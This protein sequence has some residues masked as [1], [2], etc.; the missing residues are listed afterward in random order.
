MT[1]QHPDLAWPWDQL[2]EGWANHIA[3]R[4]N[5]PVYLVGSALREERPRDIDIRIVLTDEAFMQRYGCPRWE[6]DFLGHDVSTPAVVRYH[7][8]MAKHGE[9]AGRH[10]SRGLNF[11]FQVQ[12]ETS[13]AKYA[14]QP[15]VRIDKLGDLPVP[16][17]EDMR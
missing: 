17:D 4:F 16:L 5:A 1:P 8:D 6:C 10:H 12:D 15:R 13:A 9:W 11:D 2:L 7:R 14:D 3:G